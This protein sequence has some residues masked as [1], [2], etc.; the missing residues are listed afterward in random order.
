MFETS[1]T[2]AG[3]IMIV[4]GLGMLW[5][6]RSYVEVRG[7]VHSAMQ[8]QANPRGPRWLRLFLWPVFPRAELVFSYALA[9]IALVGGIILL[10]R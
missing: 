10:L 6:A 7:E 3:V 4:A 8:R 9:A 2:T 1:D 5:S